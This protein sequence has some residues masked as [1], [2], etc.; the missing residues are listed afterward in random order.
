[1]IRHILDR[2]ILVGIYQNREE[3]EAAGIVRYDWK[4]W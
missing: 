1:M 4:V 2:D 3:Q